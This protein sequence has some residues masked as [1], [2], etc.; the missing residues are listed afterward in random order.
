MLSGIALP[1]VRVAC[2]CAFLLF[3]LV[4]LSA[5]PNDD[6][7][8]VLDNGEVVTARRSLALDQSE[9]VRNFFDSG[10]AGHDGIFPL[11]HTNIEQVLLVKTFV[12]HGGLTSN[13]LSLRALFQTL[14]LSD[15]LNMQSMSDS[16]A[17]RISRAIEFPEFASLSKIS[18]CLEKR[19]KSACVGISAD[20]IDDL[21]ARMAKLN[22]HV[23]CGARIMQYG[24]CGW[25]G[26]WGS[27]SNSWF[28]EHSARSSQKAMVLTGNVIESVSRRAF[29]GFDNLEDLFRSLSANRIQSIDI[30]AFAGLS[31]LSGLAL[32]YN[33]I[34]SI[35]AG[36]FD[37]LS[38]L[39]E[40]SLSSCRIESIGMH[41][42]RGLPRLTNLELSKNNLRSIE[43]G[44]FRGLTS[45][46]SLDL[47]GNKV[48]TITQG[49]F[50][51]LT[52][53]AKIDLSDNRIKAL[54]QPGIFDN[55]SSLQRL[56][57][58]GNP[59][60]ANLPTVGLDRPTRKMNGIPAHVYVVCY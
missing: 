23:K 31:S 57:L 58:K 50:D 37:G 8:F 44:R 19:A 55:L 3:S 4:G 22:F 18:K 20:V 21:T 11:K 1:D 6:V 49:A 17:E 10:D 24:I 12:E 47:S 27:L 42:F 28:S 13:G 34:L 53:L 39:T 16:I 40:L 41:A 29:A 25:S 30:G 5:P 59:I 7:H 56:V 36:M 43:P 32:E 51:D 2:W 9:V 52:S 38:S 15:F 35:T 60:C 33:Q 48:K 26:V 45:L 14:I 46:R 54:D